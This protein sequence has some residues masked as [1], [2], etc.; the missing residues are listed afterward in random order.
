MVEIL[1]V[2]AILVIIAMVA[3]PYGGIF[4]AQNRLPESTLNIVDALRRAQ[5]RSTS[6]M[7][8]EPWG[9]QFESAR[10]IIFKG[11][12]YNPNDVDNEAI[13]LMSVTQVDSINLNGGGDAVIFN[14]I[15]GDTDQWGSII[16]RD[17]N[18]DAEATVSVS[19]VGLIEY[20]YNL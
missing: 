6:G 4:L 3:L 19:E 14:R 15:I 8:G 9:V 16:L 18:S 20:E 1:T 11:N 17:K 5:S 12:T 7:G 13:D 2:A 10:I